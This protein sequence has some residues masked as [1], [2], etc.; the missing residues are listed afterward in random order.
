MSLADKWNKKLSRK[1]AA[2]QAESAKQFEAEGQ[3]W[4]ARIIA[5][6]P[7]AIEKAAADGGTQVEVGH[8][9]D[10]DVPSAGKKGEFYPRRNELRGGAL[11]LYDYC[12]GEGLHLFVGG[13]FKMS[14]SW[15]SPFE[16]IIRLKR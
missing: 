1:D 13:D 5:Q 16:V 7:D 2:K 3:A 15:R 14:G 8:F 9:R 11:I 4:A 6:I 10:D 12:Q